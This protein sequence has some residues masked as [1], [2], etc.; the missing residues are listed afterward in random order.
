M[1]VMTAET[2][3]GFLTI[4][5]GIFLLYL[6]LKT[7]GVSIWGEKDVRTLFMSFNTVAGVE[8]RSKVKLSGV[9]IGYVDSIVL[10]D[11]HAKVIA[12]ILRRDAVIRKNAIA[13]IRTEGL[14]GEKY[15]EIVQGTPDAPALGNKDTI[16]RTEEPADISDMANKMSLAL[17]DV[18]AI[19]SSLKNVFGTELGQKELKNILNN[20]DVSSERL[21]TLLVENND[22]L[23]TTINNFASISSDFA[24][25]TPELMKNLDRVA[26][27]LRNL[28]E[29][30]SQNISSGISNLN[31]FAGEFDAILKENRQNLKKT[32]DNITVASAKIEDAMES[33]KNMSGSI[34]KVSKKIE[35]GEGTMGKLVTDAEVYDSLNDTLK[36]ANKL[37]TKTEDIR[38]LLG[39]RG[40][41]QDALDKSKAFV[42]V[43][44]QP[45]EDKQY[46]LEVAEDIRR[47]DLSSTRNT[48][49]SL[50]YTIL[51]A[52]RYSDLTI[53]GGLIESS[54]GMGLD[55]HLFGDRVTLTA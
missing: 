23:K 2:K 7:A 46:I 8:L 24:K 37:L 9:E 54:A 18:K 34:E 35:N 52:K 29:E 13:T 21:K 12:K 26:V 3:V 11:S 40:E 6:S 39:L 22:A 5:A 51:V 17:D 45:R 48:L 53:R 50:L 55:Y 38:L 25:T 20:I 41:R 30:N 10:E 33:F 19:T 14:L 27:S 36:G 4:V 49:N 44:I 16:E 1:K 32:I 28:I 43:K 31:A 15:I 42:S 47:K